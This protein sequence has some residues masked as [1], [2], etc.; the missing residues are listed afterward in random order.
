MTIQRKNEKAFL[1][2]VKLGYHYF[3]NKY[4]IFRINCHFFGEFNSRPILKNVHIN[5]VYLILIYKTL[6]YTIIMEQA[7]GWLH[8]VGPDGSCYA[9]ESIFVANRQKFKELYQHKLLEQNILHLTL[10]RNKNNLLKQIMK[11][12]QLP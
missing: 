4:N 9:T 10:K 3:Y 11:I 5:T 6:F 12:L 8:Y 7:T 2:R 1:T